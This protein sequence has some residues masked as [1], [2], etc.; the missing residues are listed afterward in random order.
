M[1]G[2]VNTKFV[3]IF[4]AV[5]IVLVGG[6]VIM[7]QMI[8]NDAHELIAQG[9]QYLAEGEYNM[10]EETLKRAV[11][12]SKS[13][14]EIIQR[15]IEASKQIPAA[16]HVEANNTLD[17]VRAWTYQ[18]TQIDPNSE[19][20]LS[21]YADLINQVIS[22]IR[23]SG[24]PHPFVQYINQAALARLATS[25][26]DQLARRY[27]AIYGLLLLNTEMTDED[28]N[29]VRDDIAWAEQTFPDDYEVTKGVIGWKLFDAN[30]LDRLGG[31]AELAQQLRDEALVMSQTLMDAEPGNVARHLFHIQVILQTTRDEDRDKDDPYAMI[32]PNLD[33]VER[34]LLE[35]PT[36]F[37]DVALAMA[38]IK[39]VFAKDLAE[40]T[41]EADTSRQTINEGTRRAI[42]LLTRA[43]EEAPD[44]ARYKLL[45]GIDLKQSGEFEL[46]QN[47]I[48]E[49][50]S[51]STQ[52]DYLDVLLNYTLKSN[53]EIEYADLLISLAQV[54][55]SEEARQP[56][57]DESG[58]I[59]EQLI[60]AGRGEAPR[61]LLIKGRLAL[62]QNKNREGL[63]SI[64]QAIGKYDAPSREKAEAMLLSARAR[65]KQG[66]WGAAAQ[67]YE[68]LLV[69]NPNIPVIRIALANIYV[70]QHDY[71]AA[72]DHLDEVLLEDPMN[73]RAKLVQA[74]L[75][76]AQDDLDQAIQIYRDLDLPNR[77]DLAV[78]LSQLLIQNDRVEQ[79]KRLIKT[80]YD[81]DP[82]NMG[83]LATLLSTETDMEVKQQLIE[84]S[85]E[86]G[87]DPD[88]LAIL[89]RQMDPS[90]AGDLDKTIEQITESL[91]DPFLREMGAAR[92]YARA[93]D[94]EKARE[95]L[96][97]AEKL[98]P[99][100]KA[101]IDMKFS[102]ALADGDLALAQRLADT[103]AQRNLDE[104]NGR[105]YLAQVRRAN[106][107]YDAAI[108]LL[109]EGLDTIPIN[110]DGWRMLGDM[111]VANSNDLEAV[112]AYETSLKQ[113]PDNLGSIRG[114]AA[115]RDRQGR[116]EEALQMLRVAQ[117]QYPDNIQLVEIYLR[118]EGAFGDK[119]RALLLREELR[120]NAP[121]NTNNL[122]SLAILLAETGQPAKGEQIIRDL[123]A[124]GDESS[125]N[126]FALATIHRFA[127]DPDKGAQ[128]VRAYILTR[129]SQA[130]SADHLLLARYLLQSGDGN[131]ALAAYQAA[132]AV[133]S[134]QRE[135]SRE[136]AGLYF[137]RGAFDRAEPLYRD[138][139][140]QFPDDQ[141]IGLRLADTLIRLQK[142]EQAAD[143]LS[144]VDGGPTEDS[145]LR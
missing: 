24:S 145:T 68:E 39:L 28:I 94:T 67:R 75:Y 27:R 136:L 81:A 129:G 141:S 63:I 4:S 7:S 47:Y 33:E 76:A 98:D 77:P 96:A 56:M 142:H 133:E 109:R 54:E 38:Y 95:A 139:L 87:G 104:A 92:L 16:D 74:S 6:V 114:L 131:G 73:E 132:I 93:G 21:D 50:R 5:I 23:T 26:Q 1:A 30:R 11:N 128:E 103:A 13:N 64:D 59:V 86:A 71:E 3:F 105:F 138:L 60:A 18:L 25:P 48:Q 108:E 46:A 140:S 78:N 44:D 82:S 12:K 97:R 88:T 84:R 22:K 119:Q 91:D 120:I 53:A 31:D 115:I 113:K 112:T 125:S 36:P 143:V 20:Y 55:G 100:H 69:I 134:E 124:A 83:M 41:A 15:Y 51:L 10:A 123:I 9:E 135:A 79:A 117:A 45:L 107:E 65:E 85:R 122:R 101:V 35:N 17:L 40:D 14:P 90:V 43:A 118:Y 130:T 127:G 62:A 70:R 121:D 32:R 66:D 61:V 126:V 34:R 110:S 137:S 8:G 89:E 52:G 144:R 19:E 49:V 58:R 57:Y 99:D 80:Y 102:Y 42:A 2:R 72:Q 116:R 29:Q 37:E 106:K 111:Y